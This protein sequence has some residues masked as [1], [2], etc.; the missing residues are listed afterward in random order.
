MFLSLSWVNKFFKRI[1]ALFLRQKLERV[2]HFLQPEPIDECVQEVTVNNIWMFS[3]LK[4]V[5]DKLNMICRSPFYETGPSSRLQ[6]YNDI[7]FRI[8]IPLAFMELIYFTFFTKQNLLGFIS[9]SENCLICSFQ[10]T[11]NIFNSF[12]FSVSW[13]FNSLQLLY[14]YASLQA[15][16]QDFTELDWCFTPTQL[17]HH[18]KY[19]FE[20]F[21]QS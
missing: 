1:M 13:I 6:R 21:L 17:F 19:W 11:L 7:L 8:N 5:I 15:G 16:L 9:T 3:D 2:K 14:K 18:E 4:Q 10:I 12:R 20:S